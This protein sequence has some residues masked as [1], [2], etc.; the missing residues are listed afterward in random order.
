[1][2]RVTRKTIAAVLAVLCLCLLVLSGCKKEE[3]TIRVLTEMEL[4]KTTIP[5]NQFDLLVK[6]FREKHKDVTV[7]IERLPKDAESREVRLQQLRTEIMAGK[8]PDIFLLPTNT[9]EVMTL[10][11]GVFDLEPLFPDVNQAMYNGLFLD[12][13]EMYDADTEL[14]KEGLLTAVMDA[15]VVGEA[16]YTLPLNYDI[17]VI[18]LDIE[19][20]AEGGIDPS[21][22]QQGIIDLMDDIAGRGIDWLAAGMDDL[23]LGYHIFNYFPEL[24]EY[25]NQEVLVTREELLEFLRSYCA[26]KEVQGAVR[27][28]E[29]K[30]FEDMIWRTFEEDRDRF[31]ALRENV[32]NG[33]AIGGMSDLISNVLVSQNKDV[34]VEM[35]PLA[36]ADGSVIADV[37]FFGAIG[38]GCEN[39]EL[40][41]ELLRPMLKEDAQW[42]N[43]KVDGFSFEIQVRAGWPVR[44]RGAGYQIY[45]NHYK[46]NHTGEIHGAEMGIKNILKF[47]NVY[48]ED[49]EQLYEIDKA[50]FPIPLENSFG[51]S[52]MGLYYQ[53]YSDG[54]SS[55]ER[56]VD[57]YLKELQWHMGE[58]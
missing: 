20:L 57:Y 14:D 54:S 9:N 26:C 1:M 53:V 32:Q 10:E 47:A 29:P 45:R 51:K 4:T 37:T 36:A 38:A 12:I 11:P 49:I 33:A 42:M 5:N 21:I 55:A 6:Q 17:P 19:R 25:E 34:D 8:G 40:A 3:V 24:I 43:N 15:G 48:E 28:Q 13:S 7:I 23:Q 2:R 31:W 58:G 50:R 39:P 44:A 30:A 41:Y 46:Y 52:V 35:L 56:I 27:A 16:R 22:Y 18:Y